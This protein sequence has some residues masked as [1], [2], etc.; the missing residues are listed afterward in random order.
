MNERDLQRVV[1]M[2]WRV[3][4]NVNLGVDM[5]MHIGRDANGFP[6]LGIVRYELFR[7][8]ISTQTQPRNFIS[9]IEMKQE[10][11]PWQE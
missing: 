3:A 10:K 7:N 5:P 11:E 9:Q 4:S 8:L 2:C 6:Q 1:E